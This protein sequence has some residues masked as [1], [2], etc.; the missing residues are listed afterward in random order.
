MTTTVIIL[1]ILFA[2]Y[3]T[4]ADIASSEVGRRYSRR[5][6]MLFWVLA[7]AAPI[8]AVLV[9]DFKIAILGMLVSTVLSFIAYRIRMRNR[10]KPTYFDD[11]PCSD[12]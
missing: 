3:L 12:Y 8:V 6:G 7:V 5:K 10:N 11:E 9:L 2:I 1:G 4:L